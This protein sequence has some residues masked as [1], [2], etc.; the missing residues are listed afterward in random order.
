MD[1]AFSSKIATDESML[2]S[3]ALGESSPATPLT[4]PT[5]GRSSPRG[6]VQ[7]LQIAPDGDV[8][9]GPR[10]RGLALPAPG[11][12]AGFA[13]AFLPCPGVAGTVAGD[14][15]GRCLVAPGCGA[16]R[17]GRCHVRGRAFL[18]IW[19]GDHAG[20]A[21]IPSETCGLLLTMVSGGNIAVLTDRH[22]PRLEAPRPAVRINSAGSWQGAVTDDAWLC[23]GGSRSLRP[24]R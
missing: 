18:S 3:L 5:L 7:G 12:R 2:P 9:M 1:R 13:D 22:P 8:W 16:V 4:T 21:T 10:R 14:A 20:C 15:L 23:L 19:M 17:S 24:A 6:A 11:G